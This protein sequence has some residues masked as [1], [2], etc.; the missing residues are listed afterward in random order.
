MWE[1]NV[2]WAMF[3]ELT[4]FCFLQELPEGN[5]YCSNCTCRICG[6]L[7]YDK[8]ALKSPDALKCSQ[9]ENKCN[10]LRLTHRRLYD[11]NVL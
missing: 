1:V 10:F 8:E 11:L 6:D 9:C 4:Q 7:V 5:W 3:I 2:G